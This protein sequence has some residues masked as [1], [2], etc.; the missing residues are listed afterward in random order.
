MEYDGP[1]LDEQQVR[2]DTDDDAV[3]VLTIHK[4][5]GLEFP[6]VFYPFAWGDSDNRE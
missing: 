5:K 1:G 4:S 2:L 6:I 3:K